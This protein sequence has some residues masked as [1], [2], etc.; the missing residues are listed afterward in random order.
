[1]VSGSQS[2]QPRAHVYIFFLVV[3][4]HRCQFSPN[5]WTPSDWRL[6][7][8]R[9][10]LSSLPSGTWAAITRY[11]WA[12]WCPSDDPRSPA[13][14]Y[15]GFLSRSLWREFLRLPGLGQV[16]SRGPMFIRGL[17]AALDCLHPSAMFQ[18]QRSFQLPSLCLLLFSLFTEAQTSSLLL[19]LRA[20][21]LKSSQR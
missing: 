21:K 7:S 9:C 10:P 14:R 18:L 13:S 4:W 19:S 17:P 8:E 11:P 2:S 6:F 5:W 12:C 15:L 3:L 20:H 16:G 1:M